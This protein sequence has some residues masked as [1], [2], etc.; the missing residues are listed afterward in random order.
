MGNCPNLFNVKQAASIRG[1]EFHIETGQ[2]SGGH[3]KIDHAYPNRDDH[4]IED[5]GLDS[6]YFDIKGYIGDLDPAGGK[7]RSLRA[8]LK[9]KGECSFYH[10]LIDDMYQVEVFDWS[11]DSSKMQIGRID[12]TFKAAKVSQDKSSAVSPVS[13]ASPGAALAAAAQGMQSAM[14]GHLA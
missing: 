14:A 10:P 7:V 2:E 9:A 1:V 5:L 11:I 3:R 13:A 4:Y 8:A 6:D 12:F